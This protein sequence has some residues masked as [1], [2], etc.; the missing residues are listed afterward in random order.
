M[1]VSVRITLL[2]VIATLGLALL[3]GIAFSTF[4]RLNIDI[5][6]LADDTLRST[7]TILRIQALT[8]QSQAV[9]SRRIYWTNGH[10]EQDAQRASLD[11]QTRKFFEQYQQTLVTDEQDG[12]LM[13]ASEQLFVQWSAAMSKSITAALEQRLDDAILI[14]DQEAKP[15]AQQLNSALDKWAGYS[16]QLGEGSRRSAFSAMADARYK[17]VFASGATI[18]VVLLLGGWLYRSILLPMRSLRKAAQDMA[19]TL[20]FSHRSPASSNDEIG[21]TVNAFNQLIGSIEKSML[22]LQK[23]ADE[24][25]GMAGGMAQASQAVA[26]GS[27]TQS[28][29]TNSMAAAVQ[30]LTTSIAHVSDQALSSAQAAERSGES[31]QLGGELIVHT[32]KEIRE[33]GQ[34][35]ESVVDLVQDVEQRSQQID[36]VVK[37]I[38]D[39]AEQTNLLALNAAIE[40]ARAGEQGRGFAVVADEV[41]LLAERTSASTGEINNIISQMKQS[42][43][44]AS[45]QVRGAMQLALA[46]AE[47][48]AR[49]EEA[50][51]TIRDASSAAVS[52]AS[53]ISAA[54][55]QQGAASNEIAVQV[56][57]VAQMTLK[58]SQ[59]AQSSADSAES[60]KLIAERLNSEI[61]S[62]RFS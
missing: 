55:S 33:V 28:D 14:E 16:D 22:A 7:H 19:Q 44:K 49:V 8:A 31:A 40:A 26:A 3:A 62:Y 47:Q 15:L 34:S 60:L 4:Y 17:I 29:A 36:M 46:S 5:R 59:Y 58:N 45:Q 41:R 52:L 61:S 21:Q 35:I 54:I 20:D 25:Y 30:E 12:A 23:A 50:M 6:A 51:F 37:V 56:E 32:T 11:A 24:V 43:I 2:L 13:E 57:S 42:S 18:T 1:T 53:V 10:E 39:V 9:S 27:R 38:R 48:A